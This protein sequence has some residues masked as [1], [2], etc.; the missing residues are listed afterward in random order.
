MRV[1]AAVLA[2]LLLAVQWQLWFGKGGWLR[3][4]DL[5]RQ[6]TEQRA[7]NDTALA[8][9]EALKAELASLRAGGEAIEERAREQLNMLRADEIFFQ[10]PPVQAAPAR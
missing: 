4:W 10:R 9:N 3:V 2:V 5:Q 7:V 8:A 1:L 6:L